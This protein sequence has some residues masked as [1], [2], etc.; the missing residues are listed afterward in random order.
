M[1]RPDLL[2]GYQCQTEAGAEMSEERLAQSRLPINQPQPAPGGISAVRDK[3]IER[4][5]A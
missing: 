2:P 3:D 1:T 4:A 5:P